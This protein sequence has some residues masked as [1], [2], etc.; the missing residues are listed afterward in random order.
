MGPTVA[1]PAGLA[2]GPAKPRRPLWQRLLLLV[3]LLV[4]GLLF[5]ELF[6]RAL[7]PQAL[8]PRYV[9]G[10]PDGIRANMPNMRFRQW[11]PE[12]DVKIGYNGAGMRDDREAPPPAKAPGACRVALLGDSY[13]VGFESD[14]A[15]S[16]ASQLERAL[17]ARGH[18]CRVLN[19]AVSGFGHGEMLIALDSRVKAY[20]PDLVLVS[21]HSSDGKD[22]IRSAL[23]AMSPDGR[24]FRTGRSFLPGVAISDRLNRF[25]IYRWVQENSHFYAAV[26]EWAAVK[27]K[28]LLVGVRSTMALESPA[29]AGDG[30]EGFGIDPSFGNVELNRALIAALA[31]RAEAMGARLMLVEIPSSHGRLDYRAV[32]PDLIGGDLVQEMAFASPLSAFRA[33]SGPDV[34]LYLE[35]GHRHF[36]AKGNL[37]AAAATADAIEAQG[38]LAP[39]AR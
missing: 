32:A 2:A 25:R 26:R 19:F 24:L 34:K 37:L 6:L 21:L 16:Y 7:Q 38:L 3:G 29:N 17:K 30:E 36:T 13:F 9:T 27:V 11:T 33:A 1:A 10:A 15:P 12:V 14:W 8:V 28:A 5:G 31:G 23:F 18:D 35:R 22:N 4:Y 20:Q 39:P